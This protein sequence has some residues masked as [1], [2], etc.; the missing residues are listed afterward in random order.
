MAPIAGIAEFEKLEHKTLVTTPYDL[1]YSY[2]LSTNF[3]QNLNPSTPTLVFLHGYPD[4]AYMW[5]GAVQH[6]LKLPYPFILVDILG[7]GQTSK[8]LDSKMY[9]YKQQADSIA[10]ILDEEGVPNNV[11]PIGHDWGSG[12]SDHVPSVGCNADFFEGTAQRTYLYHSDRCVGLAILSLAYQIPNSEAFDLD[13]ANQSTSK[14]FGYPQ[15]EYWNFFTAKDAPKLMN[16]D[17]IRMYEVNHGNF[18]SPDPKD[19]GRDIWM[20]EMFCTPNG[21]RDYV[22]RTGKYK[23]YTVDLKPYAK[24]PELKKR[25]MERMTRDGF[26]A[27]VYY[28]HAL[29]ENTMLEDERLLAQVPSDAGIKIDVPMLYIGQ[30]GDWVCRTDLM[31]DAKERGLVSDLEE[32]VVDAGHWVLYE[33]PDDIAELIIDW[34]SRRFP[35]K[36]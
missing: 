6:F 15:W 4:D 32:K 17:L 18:P 26:D 36:R 19:N 12:E 33:K 25:Y 10:Q 27:P 29:K 24:N 31:S 8:P 21:M 22:A 14:R 23:D 20:R 2:Y 16:D 3:K 11:I 28:Y 5:A 7:L 13:E 34:L 9:N 35:V 30:T 1:T